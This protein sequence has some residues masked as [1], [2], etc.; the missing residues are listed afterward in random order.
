[1]RTPAVKQLRFLVFAGVIVGG[2]IGEVAARR[3]PVNIA[4]SI[5]ACAAA[6][7]WPPSPAPV[8]P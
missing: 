6:L 4:A 5:A 1:V 8:S 3:L 7:R 2:I